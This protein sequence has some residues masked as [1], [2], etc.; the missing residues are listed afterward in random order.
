[1]IVQIHYC[2]VRQWADSPRLDCASKS[3]PGRISHSEKQK[4][5]KK[6]WFSG[7]T[8]LDAPIVLLAGP[9]LGYSL[10]MRL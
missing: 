2:R 10:Y 9:F 5:T 8:F 4:I 3:Q 6:T 1:M 7:K